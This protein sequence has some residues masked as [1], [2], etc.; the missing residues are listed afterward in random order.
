MGRGLPVFCDVTFVTLITGRGFARSGATTINGATLRDATR[1]NVATYRE[2]VESGLGSRLCLGCE[3]FGRRA[4]DVVRIV[5]PV[6]RGLPP[7]VRRG[8]TQTLWGLLAVATQRLVARAV[9]RDAGA[10]LVTTLLEKPPSIAELPFSGAPGCFARSSEQGAAELCGSPV[11]A[12][13]FTDELRSS[14]KSHPVALRP[15]T[16]ATAL[17]SW[18]S[19]FRFAEKEAE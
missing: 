8:A 17:R 16:R 18:R 7:L 3:V 15:E 12:C 13:V 14:R 5:P 6:A 19:W 10:D 1:D 2:V 11:G 4:D 9:L